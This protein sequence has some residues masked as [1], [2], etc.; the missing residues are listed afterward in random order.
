VAELLAR[1]CHHCCAGAKN[2]RPAR[3]ADVEVRDTAAHGQR[4]PGD[5][6]GR[7]AT[8]GKRACPRRHVGM[9]HNCFWGCQ[10]LANSRT[11]VAEQIRLFRI[12]KER[13]P[14]GTPRQALVI[15]HEFTYFVKSKIWAKR[16]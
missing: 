7:R 5:L 10:R 16:V 6:N 14:E 9:A 13:W 15:V 3:L 1:R 12:V 2:S 11:R 4:R 8:V